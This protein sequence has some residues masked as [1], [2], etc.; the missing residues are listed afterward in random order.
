MNTTQQELAFC[1]TEE[2]IQELLKRL[3]FVGILVHSEKE[4][5]GI[6]KHQSFVMKT[7]AN[8][9]TEQVIAILEPLVLQLKNCA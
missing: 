4:A 5:V 6:S 9:N 1:Q 8:L 3:S 7:T 2:L